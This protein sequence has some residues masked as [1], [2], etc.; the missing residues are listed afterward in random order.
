[1]RIGIDLGGTKIE[2]IALAD[3]GETLARRRVATRSGDDSATLK[4][5]RTLVAVVG[6]DAGERRALGIA[7]PKTPSPAAGLIKKANS[8][9]LIGAPLDF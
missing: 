3:T 5:F 7:S 4:A 8:T 6:P 2:I 9:C 1:M